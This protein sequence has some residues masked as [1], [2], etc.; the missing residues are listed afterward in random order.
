MVEGIRSLLNQAVRSSFKKRF[1]F[2]PFFVMIDF[3]INKGM[4][5]GK[6]GFI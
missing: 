5:Y 2:E 6:F 4:N 3:L 1:R